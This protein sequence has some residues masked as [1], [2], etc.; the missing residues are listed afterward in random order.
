MLLRQQTTEHLRARLYEQGSF[1]E[2][3][4]AMFRIVDHLT[5]NE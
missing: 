4:Q 5:I 1:T 2:H 3:L